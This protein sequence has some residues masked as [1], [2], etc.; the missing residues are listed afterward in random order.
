MSD[1]VPRRE[2]DELL[3]VRRQALEH[4]GEAFERL[5]AA[6][7]LAEEARIRW[8]LEGYLSRES[9]YGL[10]RAHTRE[11]LVAGATEDFDRGLWRELM[12]R[13]HLASVMDSIARAEWEER[14]Q[15]NPPPCTAKTLE[16]TFEGLR[17]NRDHIFARGVVNAFRKLCSEYCTNDPFRIGS[18]IVVRD[19][20]GSSRRREELADIERVHHVLDRRAVP[21]REEDIE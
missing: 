11:K 4:V 3:D 9:L 1:V 17:E 14:L 10:G 18:R 8:P 21:T 7:A 15:K 12:N 13:T 16:A 19:A 6:L 2:L 5:A 20:V